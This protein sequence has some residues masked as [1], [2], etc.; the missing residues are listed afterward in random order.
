LSKFL[1]AW[2]HVLAGYNLLAAGK[3]EEAVAHFSDVANWRRGE[4]VFEPQ[5]LAV[6][7]VARRYWAEHDPNRQRRGQWQSASTTMTRITREEV[8]VINSNLTALPTGDGSDV[9]RIQNYT[10]GLSYFQQEINIQGGYQERTTPTITAPT[11]AGLMG[12]CMRNDDR[13]AARFSIHDQY[14]GAVDG[15]G[16]QL[17]QGAVGFAQGELLRARMQRDLRGQPQQL[18]A[19]LARVGGDAAEVLFVEEMALVV[20][21]GNIRQVNSGDGQRAAHVQGLQGR[22]NQLA[23]RSEEDRAVEW[24]GWTIRGPADPRGT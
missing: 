8:G 4:D 20:Q 19:V 22:R 13:D 11:I 10:M 9:E 7:V 15:V 16:F 23:N 14:T 18:F 6:S 21:L 1:L 5:A 3:T 2:S 12:R 17:L 24:L